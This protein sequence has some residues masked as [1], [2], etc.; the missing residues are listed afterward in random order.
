MSS[1]R[2]SQI[3]PQ[4]FADILQKSAQKQP[5]IKNHIYFFARIRE[6]S[7]LLRTILQLAVN[8][9]QLATTFNFQ[10]S[11]F[12]SLIYINFLK[13]ETFIV[14]LCVYGQCIVTQGAAC[15]CNKTH[16]RH[17]NIISIKILILQTLL[18]HDLVL[19]IHSTPIV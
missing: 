13:Y 16:R 9:E 12:N 18:Q 10:L 7:L 4:I 6:K 2:F 15:R 8:S 1:R 5:K 19:N 3:K 11:T 17:S 14:V